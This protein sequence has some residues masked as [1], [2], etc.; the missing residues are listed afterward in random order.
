MPITIRCARSDEVDVVLELSKNG[1]P[2]SSST[3]DPEGVLGLLQRDPT[4]L[5]VAEMDGRLVGTLIVGWDGWRRRRALRQGPPGLACLEECPD[6]AVYSN[7]QLHMGVYWL[8]L[9]RSSTGRSGP[10]SRM[11]R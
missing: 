7:G 4:A 3:D 1:Q 2:V 6:P 10:R 5:F 9:G 11:S 8:R